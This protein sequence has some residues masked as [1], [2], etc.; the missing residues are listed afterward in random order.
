MQTEMFLHYICPDCR[1]DIGVGL[2]GAGK[3]GAPAK[4][5]GEDCPICGG[6]P[7]V[8]AR[9]FLTGSAY[10]E[11]L[12]DEDALEICCPCTDVD[13]ARG[14]YPGCQCGATSATAAVAA[15]WRPATPT[16]PHPKTM[17]A[18]MFIA[19]ATRPTTPNRSRKMTRAGEGLG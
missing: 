3:A 12:D 14:G 18:G 11:W 1:G 13:S 19:S 8:F 16:C 4:A 10:D 9:Q 7:A 15:A 5:L 6:G 17:T 2:T